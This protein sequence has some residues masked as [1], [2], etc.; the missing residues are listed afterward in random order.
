MAMGQAGVPCLM[1]TA[2]AWQVRSA[3]GRPGTAP[4]EMPNICESGTMLPIR[5]ANGAWGYSN[6]SILI[7]GGLDG[8]SHAHHVD[9]YDP[10]ADTWRPRLD[11]GTHRHDP[12]TVV[13]P[14]GR[15]LILNGYN[16]E[17]NAGVGRAQYVDPASGFALADGSSEMPEVRGY[18]NLAILLPDGRVLVGGGNDDGNAG[19][20]KANF[21][22]YSPS[23]MFG[24]RPTLWY[25]PATIAYG[26]GFFVGASA[27]SEAVLIGL[28]SMTHSFDMNG[29]HVQIPVWWTG[30]GY[31]L[32]GGPADARVAPPGYY[33]LFVLDANRVPSVAKIVRVM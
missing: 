2:G 18:H 25:A 1:T 17:G 30:S 19:K 33:M 6:G 9:V 3:S 5:L 29:R 14:D 28:P 8:T 12:A 15:V 10:V 24:P 21:R 26:G 7:A 31:A 16:D 23:Y 4:G 20:E 13:L 22:Y 27:A 11:V 32:L